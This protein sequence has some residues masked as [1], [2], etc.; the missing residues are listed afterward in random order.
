MPASCLRDRIWQIS[1]PVL[2]V[3]ADAVRRVVASE[4]TASYRLDRIPAIT[5][6]YRPGT[7]RSA[8][9]RRCATL[10]GGGPCSSG[11]RQRWKQAP[12]RRFS[13]VGPWRM[14]AGGSPDRGQRDPARGRARAGPQL[15]P[16]PS[17]GARPHGREVRMWRRR[18]RRMH[19][20]AGWGAGPLLRNPDR[21]CERPG[22]DGR[23]TRSCEPATSP[24]RRVPRGRRN[25]VRLLHTR[26]GGGRGRAA[27]RRRRIPTTRRSSRRSTATSVAAGCTNGSSGRFGWR[28]SGMKRPPLPATP[29][30]SSRGRRRRGISRRRQSG[31]TSPCSPRDLSLRSTQPRR[32]KGPGPRRATPGSM[33]EGTA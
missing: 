5:A 22:R 6:S 31:T 7:T 25:T 14:G 11:T 16:R 33:S 27:R 32:T 24:R 26:D 13:S 12:R 10:R 1:R 4:G 19:G 2:S 23:G 15:A 28:L 17:G 9:L 20:L 21:R 8:W 29:L 18:V 3:R 30:S